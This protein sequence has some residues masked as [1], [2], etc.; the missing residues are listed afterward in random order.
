MKTDVVIIGGGP[1]G[2][3]MSMFLKERGIESIIIEKETFPRFHIGESMTGECGGVVRALGLEAKLN[4]S[5]HQVIKRGLTVYSGES[6]NNKWYV[7]VAARDENNNLVP[8]Y[9]WQVHRNQFDKMMLEEAV[10]RG[11]PLIPGMATAPLFNEDGSVRGVQVRTN[12]GDTLDIEAEVVVDAS[13][14]STFLAN[15]GVTSRKYRGNYDKQIA[16]F[17]HVVGAQRDPAPNDGD[18]LIYYKEKYHWAWFIPLDEETTSVGV[19]APAA[20]FRDHNESKEEYLRRELHEL[21]ADIKR[22]IPEINFVE[23][24]RAIPNYSFQ[25]KQ[26][27]GKGFMCIGDA[28]RFVDPI[29]S[30][31][32]YVTMKEAQYGAQAIAGYLNGDNRDADNPFEEYQRFVE[33]GIDIFED[34]IDCFWE[35]PLAFATFIHHRYPGEMIDVLAGRVFHNQPSSAVAAARTLLQRSREYNP[36]AAPEGLRFQPEADDPVRWRRNWDAN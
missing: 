17:S 12:D 10:E 18:T 25:V 11:T 22:R 8:Q 34:I 36:E 29:F 31:G 28:H 35:Y 3:A 1:G 24:T 5:P 20:Y 19:V 21:N 9:T 26:F 14:Q 13:G 4:A 16:I 32:L 6:G 15:H 30:F 7:G 2:S 33:N 27:T 23:E